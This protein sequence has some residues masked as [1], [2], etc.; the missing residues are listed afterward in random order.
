MINYNIFYEKLLKTNNPILITEQNIQNEL[1]IRL[2]LEGH[3]P[4]DEELNKFAKMG[5]ELYNEEIGWKTNLAWTIGGAIDPTG[6]ADFTHAM[7][8]FNNDQDLAGIITLI[9]C[10]PYIGDTVK[11]LLPWAGAAK[12][13]STLANAGFKASSG[14]GPITKNAA[15]SVANL[16]LKKMPALEKGLIK[17]IET[18]FKKRWVKQLLLK[19]FGRNAIKAHDR[20]LP[21]TRNIQQN[22]SQRSI[23]L[24]KKR[25]KKAGITWVHPT[26]PITKDAVW[27]DAQLAE[28]V[29]KGMLGKFDKFLRMFKGPSPLKG[30]GI[31][32]TLVGQG[33]KH[34]ALNMDL[35]GVPYLDKFS[36]APSRK[37]ASYDFM[38][39]NSDEYRRQQLISAPGPRVSKPQQK[40][41]IKLSEQ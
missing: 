20:I 18:A 17:L 27:T 34:A 30:N 15:V 23:S 36:T 25:A 35:S 32:K 22:L 11:V 38:I 12:T 14:A 6:I 29:A 31:T 26:T 3:N 33:A 1:K 40:T 8:Y 39:K 37:D 10:I 21:H 41:Y 19:K 28:Y 2:I 16:L 9:G 24:A 7:Y 5:M 4:S 13:G